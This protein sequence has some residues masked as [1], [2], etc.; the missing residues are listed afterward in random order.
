MNFL[1]A[2]FA[3]PK[4]QMFGVDLDKYNYIGCTS[5]SYGNQVTGVSEVMCH[6]FI[7]KKDQS[8]RVCKYIGPKYSLK[9]IEQYHNWY[10]NVVPLW[11]A[12]QTS[13]FSIIRTHPS[14][15]TEELMK[16]DG[17]IWDMEKKWWAVSGTA[18]VKKLPETKV[19]DNV[20]TVAFKK[21]E[22]E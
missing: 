20:I 18:P 7:S 5:I 6:F 21:D 16:E 3:K 1:K 8:D 17:Y 10:L 9:I 12:S 11:Q 22:T 15:Y 19:E 13:W 4:N 14:K 2:L